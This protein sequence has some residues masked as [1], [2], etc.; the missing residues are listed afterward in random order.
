MSIYLRRWK[1][2]GNEREKC[3]LYRAQYTWRMFTFWASSS[4]PAWNQQVAVPFSTFSSHPFLPHIE[5]IIWNLL[6]QSFLHPKW[7]VNREKSKRQKLFWLTSK[8]GEKKGRKREKKKQNKNRC[9]TGGGRKGERVA[10]NTAN[11]E[12][13]LKKTAEARWETAGRRCREREMEREWRKRE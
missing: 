13:N 12:N 5:T 6:F 10:P 4:L 7:K 11:N 9:I 3:Y 2:K 8:T 1:V